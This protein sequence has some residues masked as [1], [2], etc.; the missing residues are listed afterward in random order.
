MRSR[1]LPLRR[2]G[3]ASAVT[4]A[5]VTALL[6]APIAPLVAAFVV[7]G[8][9][10]MAWNG[11]SFTAAAELAGR[12][13]SGAALGFQQTVLGVAGLIVPVAF[14][15]T[16]SATSWQAAFALAAVSPLVG[17]ALLRPLRV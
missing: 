8:A 12:A 3:I 7:A 2:I 16:V 10:S 13:R 4:V 11:L 15:A 5:A 14:A 1:A 9:I 6:D 17:V